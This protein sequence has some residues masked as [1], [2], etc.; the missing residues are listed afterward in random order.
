[1]SGRARA[2][3]RVRLLFQRRCRQLSS[4]SGVSLR[5]S[6][7]LWLPPPGKSGY[8]PQVPSRPN[9]WETLSHPAEMNS[10]QTHL[11]AQS[12]V[13]DMARQVECVEQRLCLDEID[14]DVPLSC[15]S[16]YLWRLRWWKMKW[17]VG[18]LLF[19]VSP[20]LLLDGELKE[21]NASL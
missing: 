3:A 1:M 9:I 13:A 10:S 19:I 12:N 2:R 16:L 17:G 18:L 15:I 21:W 5:R 20:V 4:I 11:P 8:G 7:L 6:G 14:V